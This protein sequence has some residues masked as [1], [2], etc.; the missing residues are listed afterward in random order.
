MAGNF[1]LSSA[2]WGWPEHCW[3]F[4]SV[5]AALLLGVGS[6]LAGPAPGAY[7][8]DIFSGN[9]LATG[10]GVY[11]LVGDTGATIAP[12]FL[13]WITD[14]GGIGINLWVSLMVLLVAIS[15]F[16]GINSV[17]RS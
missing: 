1:S 16:V 8:A 6:G 11:R 14:R 10:V 5:T 2:A 12:L 3:C 15:L 17:K 4:R 9:D 13:G 7:L